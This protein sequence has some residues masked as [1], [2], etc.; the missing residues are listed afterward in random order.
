M[1]LGLI[2]GRRR[3]SACSWSYCAAGCRRRETGCWSRGRAVYELGVELRYKVLL[4]LLLLL[5]LLRL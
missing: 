1:G 4:W 3:D 5:L 2:E